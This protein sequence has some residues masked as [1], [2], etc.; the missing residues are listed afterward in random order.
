MVTFRRDKEEYLIINMEVP[1]DQHLIMNERENIDKYGD[2][3]A[4]NDI[5]TDFFVFIT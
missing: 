3:S 1:R 4:I 5:I 2:L